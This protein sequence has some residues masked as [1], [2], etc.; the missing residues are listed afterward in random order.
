MALGC[1][2]EA[3]APA[4]GP[5]SEVGS[6]VLAQHSPSPT[7]GSGRGEGRDQQPTQ[8]LVVVCARGI[9]GH[10]LR[11]QRGPAPNAN[12]PLGKGEGRAL[13]RERPGG[14]ASG[15]CCRETNL[16]ECQGCWCWL[17]SPGMPTCLG[18]GT[19]GAHLL[20][21]LNPGRVELGL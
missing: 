5:L 14:V 8:Q 9:W 7:S 17:W 11:D 4:P 15:S 3:E 16:H 2:G 12:G 21:R 18:L 20:L 1:P 13:G 6:R 10:R 19:S